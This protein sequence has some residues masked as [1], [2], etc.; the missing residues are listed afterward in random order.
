[1]FVS[2]ISSWLRL[3]RSNNLQANDV[4]YYFN[5]GIL[6]TCSYIYIDYGYKNSVLT[7]VVHYWRTKPY[8]I[9]NLE[10]DISLEFFF[11]FGL[12]ILALIL[13]PCW[14]CKTN[15]TE[16]TL[17]ID[18]QNTLYM[19]TRGKYVHRDDD[20]YKWRCKNDMSGLA[21][22]SFDRKIYCFT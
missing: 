5:V 21:L 18:T 8:T 22:L 13:V 20:G 16:N 11:D 3:T 4:W 12:R 17:C 10:V 14:I 15:N 9:V 1:M 7:T 2:K 19:Y 6:Y